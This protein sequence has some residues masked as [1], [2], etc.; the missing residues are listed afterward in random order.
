V[1][2]RLNTASNDSMALEPMNIAVVAQVLDVRHAEEEVYMS[3]FNSEVET[4]VPATKLPMHSGE[5][6][7]TCRR[8]A[9]RSEI[10]IKV[11][12]TFHHLFYR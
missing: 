4:S 10:G 5:M 6:L 3:C 9:S 8:L 7:Q 12:A 11:R 2:N 1:R